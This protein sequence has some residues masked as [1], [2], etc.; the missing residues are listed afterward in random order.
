MTSQANKELQYTCCSI[1]HKLKATMKFGQLIEYN[2]KNIFL[3]NHA[4]NEAGRQVTELFLFF[5]KSL[6]KAKESGL[7]LGF[8]IIQ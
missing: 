3:K 8:T 7:Q 2:T 5:R 4:E 6:H 1:F